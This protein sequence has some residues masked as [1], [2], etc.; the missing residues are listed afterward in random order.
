MK[1]IRIPIMIQDPQLGLAANIIKP[2]EG[3]D[4][5]RDFFL[6]GPVTSKVAVLE[7]NKETGELEPGARYNRGK[8]R[9]WYENSKGEN[10]YKAKGKAL[11]DPEFMQVSVFAAV[12]RTMDLFEK[13]DTL[14][15]P[16]TWAFDG[17]QLFVI[18]CAGEM[19]NAYYHRDS[20]SLQ[21]FY[22]PSEETE[23]TIYTC[24]SR[25]I[26]AHETGH[27]IV[28]G[29]APDLLDAA[30]P[31]SLAI[32][33]AMADLTALLMAFSSNNL[34]VYLLKEGNGSIK[35][36]DPNPFTAI[37]EQFGTERGHEHGLRTLDNEKTLDPKGGKNY[38]GRTEPHTLSMVLS[39]AL[40]NVM[41]EI[42][43]DLKKQL[44]KEPEY[45]N[46]DDPLFSAS[47]LA[48][49]KGAER[50]KR[51]T[52]RALDYL[53]PGEV[54]F[55]DYARALIAVDQVAYPD[56]P[57]M[58]EW[59]CEEFKRRHIVRN[60]A[61]LEMKEK[62]ICKDLENM[63]IATLQKSDWVAYEFANANRDL[64]GIP[65][66][67]PFQVRPRLVASKKYDNDNE[68]K[69]C[70]FK[71]SWDHV[72][73]N[74]LGTRYPK[75]RCITVGTNLVIDWKTGRILTRLT[76]A[77]PPKKIKKGEDLKERRRRLDEYKQQ[78]KDRDKFLRSL[79]D[80]GILK[81]GY[82]AVGPDG[83]LLLSSV[84]AEAG[85]GVMRLRG[86]A[87]MLNIT[88]EDYG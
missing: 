84:W 16:L 45:A 60:K 65:P 52:F 22:F 77:P 80:N 28:D 83:E 87:N 57:K 25:D 58:R 9:G 76:N 73:N 21:F 11:Y 17:S 67:I 35:G 81:V 53:P 5:V 31:Q 43:E 48:L 23:K 33:E 54:S 88:E 51:M 66:R 41:Y 69:E 38:V 71:V 40:F 19:C 79:A 32:H 75:K 26:V 29:I 44:A 49:Q 47:G 12:L 85:E 64:L 18:P 1:K 37:A 46:K 42:H 27:A 36:V 24:L 72:E 50:F 74:S 30:T 8:I 68:V 61:D 15:R 55:I 4:P 2:I 13:W 59:I 34:R 82:N 7:F 10:L 63:D 62:I 39:G 3:Y 56:D 6:D 86:S 70:I 78:R 20:H 14:G